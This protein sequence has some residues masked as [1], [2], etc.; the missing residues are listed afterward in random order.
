MR[1]GQGLLGLDVFQHD[2]HSVLFAR[3][4]QAESLIGRGQVPLGEADLVGQGLNARGCRNDLGNDGSLELGL[5]QSSSGQAGLV[6]PDAPKIEQAAGAKAPAQADEIIFRVAEVVGPAFLTAA[7]PPS[8]L[9]QT[10]H[11]TAC[12]PD[13]FGTDGPRSSH[14]SRPQNVSHPARRA[15]VWRAL[16]S[17]F[18]A[19]SA[20]LSPICARETPQLLTWYLR[21]LAV[22]CHF[23]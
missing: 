5:T 12:V 20:A 1:L 23:S 11:H 21:F 8:Q 14:R 9:G 4:R 22:S 17:A 13:H 16:A 18:P 10:A 2:A 3:A 19:L 6:G 15:S 7:Q